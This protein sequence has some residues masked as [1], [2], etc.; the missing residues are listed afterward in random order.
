MKKPKP[1]EYTYELKQNAV[2]LAQTTGRSIRAVALELG[3][4]AWK[5]RN[6]LK[7]D[8]EKLERTSEI[9]E[10][11]KRDREIARL[12]EE[13]FPRRHYLCCIRGYSSTVIRSV[14]I[15][16]VPLNNNASFIC[17]ASA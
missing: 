10:L 4:P 8:K 13:D 15:K 1:A 17:F 5:L 14:W 11:I 2:K 9:D 3:I 6:W 7:E 12:K 16:S